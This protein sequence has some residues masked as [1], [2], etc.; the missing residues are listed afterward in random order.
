MNKTALIIGVTGQDGSYLAQ[1]LLNKGYTVYGTTRDSG[2]A[3]FNNLKSLAISDDV[4]VLSMAPNDFRSV[5]QVVSKVKPDEI[6]N[7]SGQSSVSLSFEQPVEA[8]ESILGATV[9]ILEVIRISGANIRFY[10]AGSSEIFGDTNGAR[11]TE[12]TPFRPLSPYAVAKAAAY[13][14]VASYRSAYNL[15]ASTGILFNHESP[16][17]PRR[18]VTRKIV[19]T[20]V[21]ISRGTKSKLE[22]GNINVQ[23]DWGWAPEY[24]DAMWRMLQLD[25]PSDFVVATGRTVS[26]AYFIEKVFSCL[27][28]DW[29]NY[30]SSVTSHR[31]PIEFDIGLADP[32]RARSILK[33]EAKITVDKIIEKLVECELKS[34]KL[35]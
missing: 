12:E 24:V 9:N 3:N 35:I 20:A 23:R 4:I 25:T 17:R 30:V 10:N 13:W 26:L 22:L 21:E 5:I 34:E 15:F 32:S 28:L 33:W 8:L 29:K 31:R 2:I 7:L 18:F 27:G 16:L 6:Y 19:T 14:Q 1:L 11:A